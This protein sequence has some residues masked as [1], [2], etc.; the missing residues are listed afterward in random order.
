MWLKDFPEDDPDSIY[1]E[2]SVEEIAFADEAKAD[3]E[4][5]KASLSRLTCPNS[6]RSSPS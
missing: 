1:A 4:R 2:P 6:V 5:L 3:L